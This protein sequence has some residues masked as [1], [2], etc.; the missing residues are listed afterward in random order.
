MVHYCVPVVV[1]TGF[2]DRSGDRAANV[3]LAKRR[4][5]AV[6]DVLVDATSAL[7]VGQTRLEPYDVRVLGTEL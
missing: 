1:V 6:R 5:A 4:A 2:A 7:G 3:D